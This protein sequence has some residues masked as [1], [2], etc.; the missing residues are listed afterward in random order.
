MVFYKLFHLTAVVD[1]IDHHPSSACAYIYHEISTS[2][3]QHRTDI[4]GEVLEKYLVKSKTI[5]V[6]EL[7]HSRHLENMAVI[8]RLQV[9][10]VLF[11]L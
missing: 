9:A 11:F 2:I 8:S 1:N 7:P 3:M 6:P 5:K 4:N 10:N